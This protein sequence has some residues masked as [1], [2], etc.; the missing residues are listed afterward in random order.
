M[1]K[2][3]RLWIGFIGSLIL[4]A[5]LCLFSGCTSPKLE[6][7]GAYATS[8]TNVVANTVDYGFF[9][10]DS[11]F[12]L[13]YSAIDAAFKFERDNRA[14]LWAVSPNIKHTLDGIRPQAS[15]AAAT[16]AE[17][18]KHY[19]FAPSSAGLTELQTALA[20][21]QRIESAVQSALP[22]TQ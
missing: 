14:M 22:K 10:A 3:F 5:S 13:A 15:A 21:V 1:T 11:A 8:G 19:L 9:V 4:A 7:G 12:D 16:Y 18:R 17:A 2:R 20:A 6:A